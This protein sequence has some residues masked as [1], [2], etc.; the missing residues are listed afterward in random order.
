MPRMLAHAGILV[1]LLA[2]PALALAAYDDVT[3][4]TDTV[5]SVGG[6]TLNVSG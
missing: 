6:I 3:L 2:A 4:T 5:L 1:V